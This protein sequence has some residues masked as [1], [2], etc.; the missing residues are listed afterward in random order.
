MYRE[1]RPAGLT[2][3]VGSTGG[4]IFVATSVLM[5]IPALFKILAFWMLSDPHAGQLNGLFMSLFYLL[6]M[7]SLHKAK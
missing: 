3:E 7:I 4:D 6:S 1:S 2:A 5:G